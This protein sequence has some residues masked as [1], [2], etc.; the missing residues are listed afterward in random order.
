MTIKW[1]RGMPRPWS[2][3]KAAQPTNGASIHR[4]KAMINAGVI[5]MLAKFTALLLMHCVWVG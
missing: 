1:K 2:G 5:R 4:I 3:G